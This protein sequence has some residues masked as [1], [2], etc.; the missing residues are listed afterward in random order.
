MDELSFLSRHEAEALAIPWPDAYFSP[1]Y[2]AAVE[3][4]DRALWELAIWRGGEVLYPYLR[5]PVL[6]LLPG[7][8]G[9]WFDLVTPYGYAGT[10]TRAGCSLASLVID[11]TNCGTA[12][13]RSWQPLQISRMYRRRFASVLRSSCR[14]H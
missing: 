10:W 8:D 3:A 6:E 14:R 2:G 5:R 11:W 7:Q 9:P 4:S 1:G 12:S 13:T